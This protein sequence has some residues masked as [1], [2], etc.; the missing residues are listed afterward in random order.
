MKRNVLLF[1]AALLS[2]TGSAQLTIQ[3]GASFIVEAGATV[4][5]QGDLTS[6]ADIQ[7]AGTIQL[8]GTTPQ[9]VNMNGFSIPNIEI[10]NSTNITLAG[11]V[12]IN[13]TLTLTNGKVALNGFDLTLSNAGSIAGYDNS[14][15][16]ITGGSGRL[17]KNA[18]ST[19][20]TFPVGYDATTYNPLTIAQFGTVD[21]IG[22][23]CL[24]NALQAGSTGAAFVKEV[25][26]ASWAVSEEIAGG[27][28]LTLNPGWNETDELPGFNRSKTGLSRYDGIGWDL[29]NNNTAAATGSGPYSISRS[30]ITSLDNGGIFAVGQRPVLTELRAAPKVFLQGAYVTGPLMND[31]LRAAGVIPLT[32]PYSAMAGYSQL[33]SG[34]AET[35]PSSILAGSSSGTD[36]VDW[37]FAQLHRSSD[38]TVIAT[39]SVLL[40]RNGDVVDVDGTNAKINYINFAGEPAGDYYITIRHRNHLGARTAG[41]LSLQRNST[42]GFDFTTAQSQAYQVGSITTNNA[43]AQN[44]SVFLLWAGNINNDQYVRATSQAFP[45]IASDAAFLLS[46]ILGGNPNGTVTGYSNGD[47]NMDGRARA[48]SQAFPSIPSDVA[49][50]LSN[51]LGGNS[52]ATRREHK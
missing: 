36:I 4:T 14:R 21:N 22:V 8:K 13:N 2:I 25:V 37:V 20:F 17:V 45:S 32:E 33:G 6:N 24:Q 31:G 23:R 3:S 48:T 38:G 50:I 52:N 34:G 35:I 27:S 40:Q 9:T 18:L 42:T 49:F 11:A 47:V 46:S 5:I 30:G 12:L 41:L 44:G 28:N 29:T 15:Y 16:F 26:D 39:R 10:D 51:V 1:C 43:M 19:A 7:G